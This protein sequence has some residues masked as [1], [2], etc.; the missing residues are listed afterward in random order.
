MLFSGV[1]A[2][3]SLMPA[4]TRADLENP[5]AKSPARKLPN[6]KLPAVFLPLSNVDG[7]VKIM[8]SRG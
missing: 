4:T 3:Y 7:T 8:I 6:A 1:Q 5:G 2:E